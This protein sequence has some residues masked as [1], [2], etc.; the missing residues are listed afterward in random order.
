MNAF[1]REF[2]LFDNILDTLYTISWYSRHVRQL[3]LSHFLTLIHLQICNTEGS[4]YSKWSVLI[5][6]SFQI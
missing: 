6:I 3:V 2:G 1:Q 4:E 5:M